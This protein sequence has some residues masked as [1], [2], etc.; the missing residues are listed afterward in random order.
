MNQALPDLLSRF[1]EGDRE[2]W[3]SRKYQAR[4]WTGVTTNDWPRFND[5]IVDVRILNQSG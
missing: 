2:K 3:I 4:T 5:A 1:Y